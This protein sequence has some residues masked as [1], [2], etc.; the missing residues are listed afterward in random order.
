MRPS[1]DIQ[2]YDFSNSL[3]FTHTGKLRVL[4]YCTSWEIYASMCTAGELWLLWEP[5]FCISWILCV[6]R[7]Q[8]SKTAH[9]KAH[10]VGWCCVI[11]TLRLGNGVRNVHVRAYL[12]LL[13]G[14]QSRRQRE[15]IKVGLGWWRPWSRCQEPSNEQEKEH[16]LAGAVAIT[17]TDWALTPCQEL[18]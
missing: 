4:C 14:S 2:I 18:F 3:N 12:S 5:S 1:Q 17:I 11:N 9:R 7:D 8:L 6:Q 10:Q 15:M 16:W 13:L